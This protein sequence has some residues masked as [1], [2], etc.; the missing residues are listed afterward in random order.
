M[1]TDP[2]ETVVFEK[3]FFTNPKYPQTLSGLAPD[4]YV[5]P[6]VFIKKRGGENKPFALGGIDN[7]SMDVRAIIISDNTYTLDAVAG[8]LKDTNLKTFNFVDS[9]PFDIR[10]AYTGLAYNYNTYA[11]GQKTTIWKVSESRILPNPQIKNIA[12]NLY[13]SFI[14]FELSTLRSHG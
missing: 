6:A 12:D 2:D 7:T 9:V 10:G 8:I 5:V 4:T 11:T 3:K 13:V 14:D 1:T